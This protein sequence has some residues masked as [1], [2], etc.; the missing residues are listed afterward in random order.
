MRDEI[1]SHPNVTTNGDGEICVPYAIIRGNVEPAS[2]SLEP[3]IGEG[4]TS[5]AITRQVEGVIRQF[6]ITEHKKTLSRTGVW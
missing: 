2:K 3:Q 6:A 5:A 4:S 1:S